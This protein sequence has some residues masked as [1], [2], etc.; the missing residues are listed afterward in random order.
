MST[1]RHHEIDLL[2]GLFCIIMLISHAMRMD[3]AL[4]GAMPVDKYVALTFIYTVECWVPVFFMASGVNALTWHERH[5]PREGQRAV[6]FYAVSS[7]WLFLLGFTY[8][9]N[10]GSLARAVPDIFQL[11]AVGTF[12]TY[13]LVRARLS[14]GVLLLV[15]IGILAIGIAH[16]L[17]IVPSESVL[18]SMGPIRRLLFGHFS[19]FPWVAFFLVGVMLYRIGSSAARVSLGVLFAAMAIGSRFVPGTFPETAYE[20]MFRVDLKYALAGLGASGLLMLLA[21]LAYRGPGNN[22]TLAYLEYLG[23]DSFLFLVFHIFVLAFIAGRFQTTAG[24]YAR[25]LLALIVVLALMPMVS[26]LRDKLVAKPR[27]GPVAVTVGIAFAFV[28][29]SVSASGYK[30]AGS[31]IAFGASFPFA[32]GYPVLRRRLAKTYLEGGAS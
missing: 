5:P 7:A 12:V 19:F 26:Q 14:S 18:E 13:L 23:R 30:N 31:F 28:A 16:R 2:K 9:I 3:V 24:M 21:P 11:V 25:A 15:A 20:L 22:R 4:F 8:S 29:V 17:A 27:F 1:D 10:V 6:R 32:F